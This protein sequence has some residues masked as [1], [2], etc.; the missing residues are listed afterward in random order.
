MAFPYDDQPTV[1]DPALPPLDQPSGPIGSPININMAPQ[2]ASAPGRMTDAQAAA[3]SAELAKMPGGA[4]TSAP[5][6]T[7]TPSP[8]A[9]AGPIGSP[10]TPLNTPGFVQGL[11]DLTDKAKGNTQN[12]AG[13][14]IGLNNQISDVY[15]AETARRQKEFEQEAVL[16]AQADKAAEQHDLEARNMAKQLAAK[17]I[18]PERYWNSKSTGGKILATIGLAL[19]S[20][21]GGLTKSGQNIP[22]QMLNQ[23]IT[24]DIDAQKT[25]MDKG[26]KAYDK[27]HE[28]D[29]DQAARLRYNDAWRASHYAMGTELVKLQLGSIAAKTQNVAVKENANNL[30]QQLDGKQLDAR[31]AFGDKL[32]AE[33]RARA[34]AAASAAAAR[35]IKNEKL[36][37]EAGKDVQSLV[38][39]GVSEADA[40]KQVFLRPQYKSLRE[41]G[42]AP[43]SIVNVDRTIAGMRDA[44]IKDLNGK[45][46][47]M[48]PEAY[49]KYEAQKVKQFNETATQLQ[50]TLALP[51]EGIDV[52]GHKASLEAKRLE[53]ADKSN[54]K[55][56]IFGGKKYE[57]ANTTGASKAQE[58]M[59]T[60]NQINDLV[61]EAEAMRKKNNGGVIT[62][63]DDIARAEQIQSALIAQLGVLN[64]TGVMDS[65]EFERQKSQIQLAT[66]YSATG[67]TDA[68]LKGVR[69]LAN[70][71]GNAVARAYGKEV[72]AP[73]AEDKPAG[74]TKEKLKIPEL[75]PHK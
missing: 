70:N 62:N 3:L 34:A 8:A 16:K 29:G 69:S 20:L 35:A 30:I 49:E 56:F 65:T 10:A 27:L 42:N 41:S 43:E 13:E 4:P 22:L 61:D 15:Q 54:E 60:V 26:W 18:D 72:I 64:K 59:V 57:A 12:L 9:P 37:N 71:Y 68:Q 44:V 55:S 33:A 32:E 24:N 45:K 52:G 67:R 25:N 75:A 58:A 2:A 14:Q 11:V 5:T 47:T 21:G 17:E 39:K 28:L 50:D 31:K 51:K 46:V 7:A 1:R 53:N 19:G 66:D 40:Q 74:P 36:A 63:R 6:V 38:E 73:Q 23:S 48:L